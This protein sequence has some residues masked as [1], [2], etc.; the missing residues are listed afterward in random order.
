M[1]NIRK[2]DQPGTTGACGFNYVSSF[3]FFWMIL[4]YHLGISWSILVYLSLSSSILVY[5]S[6]SN[7]EYQGANRCRREQFLAIS[8]ESILRVNN[9]FGQHFFSTTLQGYLCFFHQT[10]VAIIQYIINIHNKIV[11][12]HAHMIPPHAC[13]KCETNQNSLMF[14][15]RK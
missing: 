3:D 13:D 11:K 10:C 8:F 2:F 6:L 4:K 14:S 5:L 7:I 9:L 1:M 12:R 15:S